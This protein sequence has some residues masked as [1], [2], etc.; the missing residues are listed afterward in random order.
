MRALFMALGLSAVMA[1][2]AFAQGRDHLGDSSMFTND[3]LGDR[4]DRWRTGSFTYS[5]V[6][7]SGPY[8][9]APRAFGDILEFR[10]RTDIFA[11]SGGSDFPGDRPYAGAVSLGVLTHWQENDRLYTFGAEVTAIG[12]QTGLSDIQR[13]FHD[14][15]SLPQPPFVD[16]QLGDAFALNLHAETATK[17]HVSDRLSARNFL[18]LDAGA[19]TLVRIGSDLRFSGFGHNDLMLRD[20]VT[21]HLHSATEHAGT[22]WALTAGAD[23]AHVVDSIFLPA[24][25]VAGLEDMRFR[26][27]GGVEYKFSPSAAV[28]YGAT[29]LSPEFE[30][31]PEGQVVGSLRLNFNF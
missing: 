1:A 22:G 29:Y 25:R 8:T 21:G 26:A 12:P 24:D 18:S 9:A 27:R 5:H 2:P 4:G 16:Q 3:F 11:P 23:M 13:D 7:G 10:L 14:R 30:G 20:V 31:Q 17:V 28:F 15:Y 19:E 6:R